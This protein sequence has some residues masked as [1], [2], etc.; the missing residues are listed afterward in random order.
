[1]TT[2][3]ART[4]VHAAIAAAVVLIAFGVYSTWVIQGWGYTGFLALAWREPWAMQLLLDL[5]IACWFG[6]GWLRRDAIK[7]GITWWPYL[8]LIVFAGSIGLLVYTVL[9]VRRPPGT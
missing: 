2:S 7:R 3:D 5:G 9:R 1:M 6:G 8:V 4:T